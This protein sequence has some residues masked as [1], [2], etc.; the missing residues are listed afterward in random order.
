MSPHPL[1]LVNPLSYQQISTQN[2]FPSLHHFVIDT[3]LLLCGDTTCIQIFYFY[4]QNL[5]ITEVCWPNADVWCLDNKGAFI[6]VSVRLPVF[7][8]HIWKGVETQQRITNE[9]KYVSVV[10]RNISII[11]GRIKPQGQPV[12]QQVFGLVLLCIGVVFPK[13][14]LYMENSTYNLFIR[15][16]FIDLSWQYFIWH[17][18]CWN[19]KTCCLLQYIFIYIFCLKGNCCCTSELW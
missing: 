19:T 17:K 6:T 12:C 16:C 11:S 3:T 18:V 14:S 13:N 2:L 4:V 10:L 9:V 15:T 5:N 8:G 1:I 7:S